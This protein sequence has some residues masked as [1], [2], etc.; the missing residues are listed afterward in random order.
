MTINAMNSSGLMVLIQLKL[1]G[2]RSFNAF[3]L[4]Y[5]FANE[6]KIIRNSMP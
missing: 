3:V 4:S 1:F 2:G 5:T 6:K